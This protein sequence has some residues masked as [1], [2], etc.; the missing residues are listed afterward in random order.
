[1]KRVRRHAADRAAA[2]ERPASQAVSQAAA[3]PLALRV[4]AGLAST[5]CVAAA[6]RPP[7]SW[8]E[9]RAPTRQISAGPAAAPIA[10][11][12]SPML[13]AAWFGSVA[14]GCASP[15]RGHLIDGFENAKEPRIRKSVDH[16]GSRRAASLDLMVTRLI[17]GRQSLRRQGAS[18][19]RNTFARPKCLL[20]L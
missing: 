7:L 3:L 13:R 14:Q 9:R 16:P 15:E 6:P 8:A 2:V 11:H 18:G 17:D 19:R 12:A 20:L 5:A 10:A 1:V 4:T